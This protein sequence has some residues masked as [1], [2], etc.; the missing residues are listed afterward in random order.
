MPHG[1]LNY[2]TV[3]G[4]DDDLH[5]PHRKCVRV[6]SWICLWTHNTKYMSCLCVCV[7]VGVEFYSADI[8]RLPCAVWQT[9]THTN[10]HTQRMQSNSTVWRAKT[11]RHVC[12]CV[13]GLNVRRFAVAVANMPAFLRCLRVYLL[14]DYTPIRTRRWINKIPFSASI[15]RKFRMWHFW[16]RLRRSMISANLVLVGFVCCCVDAHIIIICWH[17]LPRRRDTVRG[18]EKERK[19]L[20]RLFTVTRRWLVS[21]VCSTGTANAMASHMCYCCCMWKVIAQL[22]VHAGTRP[23]C[24]LSRSC[25]ALIRRRLV[26]LLAI[27]VHRFVRQPQQH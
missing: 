9:N 15:K 4:V 8:S 24:M 10:I 17:P 13:G 19:K 18:S 26:P 27:Q 23:A 7:F 2:G 16:T 12:A 3:G 20:A 1:K 25:S 5:W 22:R 14:R 6:K 21:I 11:T